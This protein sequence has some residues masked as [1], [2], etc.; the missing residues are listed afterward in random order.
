MFVRHLFLCYSAEYNGALQVQALTLKVMNKFDEKNVI[1][2][3]VVALKTNT[4]KTRNNFFG[5]QLLT[6]GLSDQSQQLNVIKIR[7]IM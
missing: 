2:W 3:K 5:P 6:R 1:R 4:D 7:P